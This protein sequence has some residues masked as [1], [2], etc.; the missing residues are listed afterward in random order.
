MFEG[1]LASLEPL[2]KDLVDYLRAAAGGQTQ[3]EWVLGSGSE[4]IYA[5]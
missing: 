4:V 3:N 2:N 1:D 5:A